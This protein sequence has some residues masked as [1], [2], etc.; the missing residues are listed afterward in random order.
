MTNW[1]VRAYPIQVR[2]YTNDGRWALYS[3][4]RDWGEN[5]NRAYVEARN[6]HPTQRVELVDSRD[7]PKQSA[8]E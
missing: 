7:D 3:R 5:A 8:T 1:R 4:H 6:A 2:V